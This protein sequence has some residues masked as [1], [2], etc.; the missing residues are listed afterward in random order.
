MAIK[1]DDVLTVPEAAKLLKISVAT[2][3]NWIHIEGFPCVKV[4]NC[5]RILRALLL[6]WVNE[7]ARKGKG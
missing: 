4:G 3:Y 5:R 6:E 1:N 7:Q 2:C